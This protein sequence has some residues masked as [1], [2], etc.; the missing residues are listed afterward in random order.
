MTSAFEDHRGEG[1][2]PRAQDLPAYMQGEMEPGDAMDLAAH[3]D[4]CGPCAEELAEL[5]RLFQGLECMEP[6]SSQRQD[7]AER[8]LTV[9]RGA[10]HPLRH[11]GP[12]GRAWVGMVAASIILLLFIRVPS[13]DPPAAVSPPVHADL[14]QAVWWLLRVQDEDG[15]W[16]P[17]RWDGEDRWRIGV[18]GLVVSALLASDSPSADTTE[19]LDRAVAFLLRQQGPTGR[20]GPPGAEHLYNHAPALIALMDVSARHP[21]ADLDRA[22]SAAVDHLLSQQTSAGGWGYEGAPESPNAV[23]SGW[24]L[25]ALMRARSRGR[26]SLDE[27]IAAAL[28]W[29]R[30]LE[31]R[32][33]RVGYNRIGVFPHGC[34]TPTSVSFCLGAASRWPSGL[35]S[36]SLDLMSA[37]FLSAS[38]LDDGLKRDIRSRIAEA[39]AQSG[40]FQGSFRPRKWGNQGGRVCSTALSLIALSRM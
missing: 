5:R 21:M 17:A 13:E 39:Q 27:P 11:L 24:P 16:S 36:E 25:E 15:G 4:S 10:L 37:Y 31:D 33:G 32:V 2:C 26:D 18:T 29:Y 20:I 9:V 35:S 3:L 19:S 34:V 28:A 30:S 8:V 14:D 1:P 38:K 12:A 23:I 6:P 7:L 22:C 40:L